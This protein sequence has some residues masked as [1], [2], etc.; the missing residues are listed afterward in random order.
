M[1]HYC[2]TYGYL[3]IHHRDFDKVVRHIE[4]RQLEGVSVAKFFLGH[5]DNERGGFITFCIGGEFKEYFEDNP[6]E[7]IDNFL[8]FLQPLNGIC[9]TICFESELGIYPK[10]VDL[11][12]HD[13]NWLQMND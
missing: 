10:Q 13:N 6:S 9:C 3:Q 5:Y 8:K 2:T 7:L 11:V 1:G 4:K 12:R